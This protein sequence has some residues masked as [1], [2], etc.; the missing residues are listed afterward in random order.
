MTYVS[1]ATFHEGPTDGFYLEVLLPR[2]VEDILIR[3]GI[4]NSDVPSVP[5]V[6]LG[7]KGRRTEEV[8]AEICEAKAALSIVFI[9]A[10]TGGRALEAGLANRS[11]AFCDRCG[12]I[13]E[14]PIER[15]VSIT[16]RHETEAWILADPEA[17][18]DAMGYKGD[19]RAIG[20]P[21]G[22]VQAERLIDPKATLSQALER[23]SGRRRRR[24][25]VEQVL[26][27]VAQRQSLTALRRSASFQAFEVRLRL[28]LAS[29]GCIP[30]AGV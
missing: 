4:R 29:L 11:Q 17:I 14:W 5:A 15:C 2:V 6:R 25:A 26:S 8:A 30:P 24:G 21:E 28:A 1:W 22:A 9:H 13:C 16:P 23:I 27:A 7:L 20:L 12:E 10:D 19:F 18:L 3:D